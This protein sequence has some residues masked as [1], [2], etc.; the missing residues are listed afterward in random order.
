[1]TDRRQILLLLFPILVAASPMGAQDANLTRRV[2]SMAT[3][4][5]LLIRRYPEATAVTYA[6]R[7]VTANGAG[8][9]GHFSLSEGP[10]R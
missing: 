3:Q 2:A 5:L 4:G 8:A 10:S 7:A 1:M 6:R 9:E